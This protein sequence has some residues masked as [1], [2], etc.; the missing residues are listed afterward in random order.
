MSNSQIINLLIS[1]I[2][3]T[4]NNLASNYKI[5]IIQKIL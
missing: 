5:D 2:S 3:L 1:I 4:L